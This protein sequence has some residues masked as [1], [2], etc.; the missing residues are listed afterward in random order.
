MCELCNKFKL[1]APFRFHRPDEFTKGVLVGRN[2]KK[3]LDFFEQKIYPYA[4]EN[5]S[6][7][8]VVGQPGA[9]KTQLLNYLESTWK[10][11]NRIFVLLNLKDTKVSYD[12]LVEAVI[13]SDSFR[14][15]LSSN[16]KTLDLEKST[17][18]KVAE[19]REFIREV[20]NKQMND[21]FGICLLM[22]TVDEYL[23]KI[24]SKNVEKEEVQKEIA[25][26]L[27]K[28]TG[29]L[30]DDLSYSCA[31]FAITEDVNYK[32]EEVFKKDTSLKSRFFSVSNDIYLDKSYENYKLEKLDEDE[33]EEMIAA[34]LDIWA[35]RNHIS[36]PTQYKET[37]IPSGLNL[38]PFS[39][40]AINL[41]WKAGAIPGDTCLAC[42]IA[43]DRKLNFSSTTSSDYSHL[44]V[45]E[46]DA[47]WIVN[48]FS[49]YFYY[50]IDLKNKIENLLEGE[51]LDYEINKITN[52]AKS[53]YFDLSNTLPENFKVYLEAFSTN[54]SIS[55]GSVRKFIK[56]KYSPDEDFETIDLVV[57]FKKRKIGV[58]FIVKLDDKIA[59]YRNIQKKTKI[60]FSALK[61]D[62]I[63]RGLLIL[64]SDAEFEEINVYN[65]LRK[66]FENKKSSEDMERDKKRLQNKKYFS[67]FMVHRISTDYAWCL[68]GLNVFVAG[69][70]IDAMKKYSRY[71]DS[72]I[73]MGPL[74]EQI[75]ERNADIT[76]MPK[77]K[78]IST[79]AILDRPH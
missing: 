72:K 27:I 61:N 46:I 36:L 21:K 41:F 30:L 10:E 1:D 67:T 38:F 23:R 52:T 5:P 42:L 53:A 75:L 48:K 22:D 54:F 69:S 70:D 6:M 15:F 55:Q 77:T 29:Q 71:I 34:F 68:L 39:R 43:L 79:G 31:I 56:D 12:Y 57:D 65:S 51:Q 2:A 14:Y 20:R 44:I 59:T 74:F 11:K 33:T 25:K 13:N 7:T 49:S 60:L 47:A 4:M 64:I 3:Y 28:I 62:A 66:R 19:I 45:T 40:K 37:I 73:R 63:E 76:Y 58:Q 26:D 24:N 35:K 17:T 32:F 8:V 18:E 9:G 16:G 78:M 50:E